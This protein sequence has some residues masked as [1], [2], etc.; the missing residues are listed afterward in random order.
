MVK[1]GVELAAADE[2]V[3]DVMLALWT[4]AR[5]YDP[6]RGSVSTWIF[7][8]ARNSLIDRVRHERRPEVDLADP[9]LAEA[10]TA[11]DVIV[12]RDRYAMAVKHALAELPEEQAHVVARVYG[13]GQ[14]LADVAAATSS[15]L[16]TVKT[17]MRLALAR[18][19][20][21]VFADDEVHD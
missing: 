17:R 15:P 16:G 12:E 21:H 4:K 2:L 13:E 18:L 14:S 19:R 6:A 7:T 9:T 1:R 5:Y 10:P 20:A 3:Q 8:V 11:P